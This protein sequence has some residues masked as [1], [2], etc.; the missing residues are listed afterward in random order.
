MK[1]VY[2]YLLLVLLFNC[3]FICAQKN[4]G[5]IIN[6]EGEKIYVDLTSPVISVGDELG[7]YVAGGYMTHP[8]TKQR[9][10]KADE[11]ICKMVISSIYADYSIALA[12]DPSSLNKIKAGQ[13]VQLIEKA[14]K[15][16][17]NSSPVTLSVSSNSDMS[18]YKKNPANSNTSMENDDR[19]AVVIAPAE[20][21]DVVNSGHFGGYVADVLME[22][23]LMNNKVRLLDRSVLNAQ[24]KGGRL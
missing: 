8:V 20:I 10:K 14:T 1:R 13:V 17:D 11:L 9:V 3:T 6:I 22:Q 16:I 15:K 21:N 5:Y 4:K 2:F 19:I 7:V 24:L 23:L 12:H 18:A